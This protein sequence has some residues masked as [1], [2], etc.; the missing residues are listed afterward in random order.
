VAA[1]V[2]V[3]V[4]IGLPAVRIRGVQLAVVTLA[5]SAPI[6]LLLLRNQVIFGDAV[7]SDYPVA[8]P[9]WFGAYVGAADPNTARTDYW[10]FT[11]FAVLV[12][13]AVAVAVAGLR[14]GATGRRFL[15]VRANERAAAAA[16]INVARTKLTGFAI[17]AGIAGLAGVLQSYRLGSMRTDTYGL[18]VGLA[19][20]AFV[21]L[22]GITSVYGAVIGG[23]L[24]GGTH[25]RYA[26]R[27]GLRPV[28]PCGWRY[29]PDSDGDPAPRGHRAGQRR[30]GQE[31]LAQRARRPGGPAR[32]DTVDTRLRRRRRSLMAAL[33]ET[34]HLSVTFGGLR[35]N[36]DVTIEIEPGSFVGLIGPNGAGK[37]TFIDAITG[38]VDATG[39]VWFDG[40]R[41]SGRAPHQRATRGLVR[42]FQS[43]ELFEDLT[44][45]DNLLVA[46]GKTRW[47]TPLLDMVHVHR[48]SADARTRVDWALATVGL[49]HVRDR[50]PTDLPHGQRKLVG[51][52]RALTARPK[53]LLLDEPAAG[54][55]TTESELLGV[56]LRGL[57]R[58]GITVFLIDHDMGL[59]L[60]VC[61]YIYVLDFGRILAEG[62]PTEI[63]RNP[64]V[65]SAYLGET[66]R[67]ARA[68]AAEVA[69]VAAQS[70]AGR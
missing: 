11:V 63:R 57:L 17:A 20:F 8:R 37:T 32:T 38:Y 15:A 22:G 28:R 50:L 5:A 41:I 44:V 12:T 59:V 43:V 30:D 36:D 3:G 48:T 46:A 21:Y 49:P 40:E 24:V 61:D 66:G 4:L 54:L 69:E 14:R 55:D 7:D 27:R 65:I 45:E 47:Y 67:E 56:H 33:L 42:T 31:T 64:K 29:R 70:N 35:A 62:T 19:L 10:R 53:L 26:R 34:R 23:L 13:A 51:V 68:V 25:P 39:E 58:E 2:V 1:A 6:G 18:F 9:E 60:G 52:A 16:G